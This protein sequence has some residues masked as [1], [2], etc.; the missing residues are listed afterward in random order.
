MQIILLETLNKLGKAGEIVNVKDGF[1]RNF[2]LPEK[3][4]LM[5]PFLRVCGV[6]IMQCD[7]FHHND[8]LGVITNPCFSQSF[9]I[10]FSL[11][12]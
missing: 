1:A 11:P 7:L 3:K 8:L 5:F 4:I 6:G 9:I 2:L 10:F 12:C